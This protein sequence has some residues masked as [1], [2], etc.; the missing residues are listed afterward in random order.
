MAL[1]PFEDLLEAARRGDWELVDESLEYAHITPERIRW[2]VKQGINDPSPD[3]RE[4]AATVLQD[5]DPQRQAFTD[6]E[7]ETLL[8]YECNVDNDDIVQYRIAM[9][10]YKRGVRDRIVLDLIEEA[11]LN[12]YVHKEA[13]KCLDEF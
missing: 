8:Q 4:L 6:E 10:L 9:A 5:S 1:L 2:A 13:R 11:S 7:R 12:R 3:V